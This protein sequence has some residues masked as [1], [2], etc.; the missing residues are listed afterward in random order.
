MKSPNREKA[1]LVK[2]LSA[3]EIEGALRAST[4]GTAAGL[5]GLTYKFWKKICEKE[6]TDKK[7]DRPTFLVIETLRIIFNDIEEKGVREGTGF[8]EGWMCPLYK[9][10]D[11]K[12]ISNYRPI[13]L[14]NTDYKLLTKSL[15]MKLI[16]VAP[17]IINKAQAG[18]MPGRS[19]F[20]QVK[21]LKLLIN[22]TEAMDENGVIVV[23]DQEKAYNKISYEYLWRTMRKFNLPENLIKTVKSLYEG[24]ETRI[25]INGILSAPF[26]V[27]RGVRQGDPL[28]CLLLTLQ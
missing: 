8:T 24:A 23:L 22:Y 19:I 18:F 7:Q 9:K 17:K 14:L 21:L 16:E 12:D 1:K 26:K 11:K 25:M 5:D 13:T 10:K 15:A 3:E 20:D 4:N 6:L 2:R 28:L 27:K